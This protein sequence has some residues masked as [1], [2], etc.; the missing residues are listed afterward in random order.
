MRKLWHRL[1]VKLGF[2][3]ASKVTY[4]GRGVLS[5]RGQD[6]VWVP[7]GTFDSVSFNYDFD[8]SSAFELSSAPK[9]FIAGKTETP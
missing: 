1:L 8:E 7:L 4:Y 9:T 5:I 3:K 2:R 6:G